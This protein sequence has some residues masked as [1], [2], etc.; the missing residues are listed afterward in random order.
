MKSPDLL[1][2]VGVGRLNDASSLVR[3]PRQ[4]LS[5]TQR[6]CLES[7][8]RGQRQRQQSRQSNTLESEIRSG[9][10]WGSRWL[11]LEVK[12]SQ[13]DFICPT[14]QRWAENKRTLVG[15]FLR[16][17]VPVDLR[18]TG[19]DQTF[20]SSVLFCPNFLQLHAGRNWFLL[21]V[22]RG[23]V[24]GEKKDVWRKVVHRIIFLEGSR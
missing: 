11:L 13:Q 5:R 8:N 2:K 14:G 9:Y 7:G 6:D 16:I 12:W 3:G 20:K 1:I 4:C 18:N 17:E 23:G 21:E 24:D 15:T 22:W 10:V 19:S